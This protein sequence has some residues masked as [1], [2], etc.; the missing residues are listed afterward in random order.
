MEKEKKDDWER[1]LDI[2][3]GKPISG[4]RIKEFI[5]ELLNRKLNVVVSK[6]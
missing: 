5:R 6:K 2:L 3:L 4:E 1:D